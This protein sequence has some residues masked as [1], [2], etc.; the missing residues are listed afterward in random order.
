VVN[1]TLVQIFVCFYLISILVAHPDQQQSS[2]PTVYCDL[3]DCLVEALVEELLSDG[4]KADLA[5]L[6]MY[7]PLLQLLV[8]LDDFD[9]GGRRGEYSLNPELPVVGAMLFW[10]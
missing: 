4:A 3:P 9:L 5:C 1:R 8:Q 6:A 7:E 10:R 2:L